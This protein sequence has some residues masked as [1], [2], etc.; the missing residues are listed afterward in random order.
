MFKSKKE[1]VI[2]AL[3]MSLVMAIGME[4]YNLSLNNGGLKLWM[5]A[6]I[7]HLNQVPLM[8]SI[9]FIMEYFIAGPKALSNAHKLVDYKKDNKLFITIITACCTVMLMCPIMSMWATLIFKTRSFP[10]IISV[11]LQTLAL[12]FPM[13][14][15][16][17]LFVAGPL[18][19]LIDKLIFK[20]A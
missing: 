10:N 15:L 19:R 18:V 8:A 9:V 16:Y 20:R 13:A 14:L 6:Y 2:F 4:T 12:N 1:E 17:Q 3:I 5:F 11:Y 7:W